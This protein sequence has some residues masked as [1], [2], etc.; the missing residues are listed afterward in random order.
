MAAIVVLETDAAERAFAVQAL[1]HAGHTAGPAPVEG[2]ASKAELAGA[3][4]VVAELDAAVSAG[5]FRD[6]R[7][8]APCSSSPRAS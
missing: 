8:A 4:A 7:L 5:L 6:A 2:H 1:E 3:D